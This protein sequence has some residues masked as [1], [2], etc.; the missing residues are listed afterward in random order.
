LWNLF[1]TGRGVRGLGKKRIFDLL[2]W[3]PM[4][5]ADYVSEFFETEL[6]RAT[7]AARGIFGTALG[8][9]SA[10]STAVL[11]LRAAA[12]AHPAGSASFPHGGLGS[13]TRALAESARQAGAEIRTDA[14]VR[15]IR[16]KDGAVAGLVLANGDEIA[17]NAVVSGVDPKRTFFHLLDPSQLDPTFALRI[18]NFRSNGTV[19]KVHL[20]LNDLP[21][22][23]ALT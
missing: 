7:I 15:H 22:F 13:F 18:K 11:L 10:G 2:R 17:A 3:G 5:V 1:K 8:P 14:E 6:I 9:W 23:P 12:D 20:A 16:V 19:A 21:S 4:A